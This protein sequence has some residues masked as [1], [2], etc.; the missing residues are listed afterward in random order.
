MCG[1]RLALCSAPNAHPFKKL[2]GRTLRV[3]VFFCL[4]R[5]PFTQP[6]PALPPIL[7]RK[8]NKKQPATHAHQ[9]QAAIKSAYP[10][11]LRHTKYSTTDA[12]VCA[13]QPQQ[14][15]AA[16]SWMTP[17][18]TCTLAA[19]TWPLCTA[20]LAP[21][22]SGNARVCCYLG[23]QQTMYKAPSPRSL[24]RPTYFQPLSPIYRSPCCCTPRH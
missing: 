20:D 10:N 17:R 6:H 18:L 23:H 3:A 12:A 16:A 15:T 9:A 19:C 11:A 22:L 5:S 2:Y 21:A 4:L 7:V 14:C 1:T 8:N 24:G 13:G